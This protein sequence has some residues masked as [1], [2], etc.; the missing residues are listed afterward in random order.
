MAD[1]ALYAYRVQLPDGSEAIRTGGADRAPTHGELADY[2][3]NQGER[4]LGPVQMSPAVPTTSQPEAA[5]A[6][7]PVPPV[8]TEAAPSPAPSDAMATPGSELAPQATG[9]AVSTA[10]THTLLPERTFGSQVPSIIG[11]TAAGGLV[12]PI[13]PVAAPVAAGLGSAVGEAGRTL[14]EQMT[15]TAPAEE[16]TPW[17]REKRAFYRGATGE[18]LAVPIRAGAQALVRAVGPTAEAAAD[19]APTLTRPLPAEATAPTTRVGQLI[20]DPRALASAELTP[21][22]QATVLSAWW[23]HHAAQGGQALG[24]AWDALGAA[25]QRALAGENVGSVSTLVNTARATGQPLA[26]MTVRDLALQG[27]PG[28]VAYLLGHPYLGA[29]LTVGQQAARGALP[30]AV[31]NPT[32]LSWLGQLPQAAPL[33]AP[34][35]FLLRGGM[36]AATSR[37]PA[38]ALP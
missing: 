16:G 10:V 26:N 38:W 34:A 13:M 7:A 5:P 1:Q 6:P 11:A 24:E 23:Q 4:Y 28:T 3:A 20:R 15:G 33:A 8:Q 21:R 17:E 19:V 22:G 2:A 32:T 18:I 30:Y 27:G 29:A 37:I 14:Y 9:H 12:A 36:Q 25:G 35:D 31:R